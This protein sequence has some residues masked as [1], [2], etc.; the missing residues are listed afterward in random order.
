MHASTSSPWWTGVARLMLHP[1][2]WRQRASSTLR[3]DSMPTA[4]VPHAEAARTSHAPDAASPQASRAQIAILWLVL[5]RLRPQQLSRRPRVSS[6]DVLPTMILCAGHGTRLKPLSD[7]C[8]KPLVPVGDAPALA[9]ILAC[10]RRAHAPRIVVNAH[11]RAEDIRAF[12]RAQ[13]DLVVSDEPELLGT[14]GGV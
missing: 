1:G 12:S 11:H 5:R 14:A 4:S 2:A 10:V 7:W 8:A 9:H 3:Q 6:R 13:G